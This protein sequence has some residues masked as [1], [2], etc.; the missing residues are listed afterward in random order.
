MWTKTKVPGVYTRHEKGCA[1]HEGGRCRG[2]KQA[3]RV[4]Y[5]DQNDR[6]AAGHGKVKYSR[7]FYNE[8]E[9]RSWQADRSKVSTPEANVFRSAGLTFNDL[10]DDWYDLAERGAVAKQGGTK[11]GAETLVTYRRMY[12]GHVRNDV[13]VHQADKL[14]A[15]DW[16]SMLDAMVRKGLKRNTVSVTLNAV[17]SVYRWACS[18]NRQLLSANATTG[19]ELPAYDE[20]PRDRVATP[21][22]AVALLAALDMTN[23]RRVTLPQFPARP[24]HNLLEPCDQVSFAISLY[25]GLR[26]IERRHVEWTDIDP[27]FT[28]LKVRVSKGEAKPRTL[29]I[30]SPL[31]VI[32]K[33]EWLRQGKPGTGLVCVGPKGGEPKLDSIMDRARKMWA[34]KGLV[35]IGFHECRHTFITTMIAAG[36]NAK[37]VSIMAG[38]ASI[39]VTYDRYG[40]LFAGH[41]DEICT[42]LDAY[43]AKAV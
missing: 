42:L 37:A 41:E 4:K 20:T 38:H 29:P 15:R 13:G 12:N 1:A 28:K 17:R 32:L 18:P 3:W 23:N 9:A 5:R 39:K 2:C 8:G 10:F 36:A 26:N 6:D 25:A 24:A 7:T 11:Y 35:P 43:L 21:D 19:L 31:R 33:R 14:T 16:Q 22:E 34:T 30:V 27:D 40:H